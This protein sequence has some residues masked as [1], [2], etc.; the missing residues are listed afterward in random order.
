MRL[1]RDIRSLRKYL[2]DQRKNK[3]LRAI[4]RDDFPEANSGTLSRILSDVSYVPYGRKT[5][6]GLNLP[7]ACPTCHRKFTTRKD[8]TNLPR[9]GEAGW[10]TVYLKRLAKK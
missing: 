3:G 9:I 1:F 8:K 7:E 10:E 2:I 5:R 4:Q 6:H